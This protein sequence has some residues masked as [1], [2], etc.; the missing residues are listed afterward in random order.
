MSIAAA[1]LS[2]QGIAPAPRIATAVNTPE[3]GW[4]VLSAENQPR[5]AI[6][7]S[8]ANEAALSFIVE[9]KPYWQNV[10]QASADEDTIITWLLAGSLPDWGGTPLTL[11][12][13]LEEN[14]TYLAKYI[15][16]SLLEAALSQ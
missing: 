7:A 4:V 14:N 11:V 9:G 1:S 10:G 2:N 12:V 8:A 5:E 6:Q 16:D 3:Q 13:I 15:G